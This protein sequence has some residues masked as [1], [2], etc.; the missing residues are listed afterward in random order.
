MLHRLCSIGMTVFMDPVRELQECVDERLREGWTKKKVASSMQM[1]AGQ[2]Q[3]L[4]TGRRP[5]TL[6]QA[7]MIEREFGIPPSSW[8]D[9]GPEY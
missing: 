3:H 1:S 5:P 4:T 6:F 9:E 2:L 7:V 8:L